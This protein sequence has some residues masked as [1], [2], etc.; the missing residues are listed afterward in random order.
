M[1]IECL[2]VTRES[3]CMADDVD[4]PHEEQFSFS[5][6]L[7]LRDAIRKI[8]EGPYLASIAGGQATWITW[9]KE[10]RVAVVAQQWTEPRFLDNIELAPAAGSVATLYF[11]Y[12]AQ[13]APEAVFA[14][15]NYHD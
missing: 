10:M 6:P 14:E 8:S 15:C 4:A 1:K 7:T 11:Q 13:K 5:P 12:L 2:T 9:Y 3:V